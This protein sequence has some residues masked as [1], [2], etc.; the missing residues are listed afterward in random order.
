VALLGSSGAGKSTLAN[1]FLG[2]ERQRTNEVRDSDSRGRHTTTHRELLPLQGGGALIDTPGMRELQLWAGQD[3]VDVVFDE[4]SAIAAQCRFR[5]CSHS[6]E[7]GCAVEAAV[8]DGAIAADRWQSY[9][10]L[11]AEAQRHE[12]LAD[13]LAAQESK[14]KLKAMMRNVKEMYKHKRR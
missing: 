4:I 1:R 2:D 7:P 11:T 14:K 12:R 13:P 5:D 10:K 3:S 9:R 6:G 8:D